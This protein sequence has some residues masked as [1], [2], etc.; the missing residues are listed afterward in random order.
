MRSTGKKCGPR[1]I[2]ARLNLQTKISRNSISC[3]E[4]ISILRMNNAWLPR[5]DKSLAMGSSHGSL[6]FVE[7][8]ADMR[9]LSGSR[10]G[11]CRQDV[12]I[13]EEAAG[14]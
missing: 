12:L 11:N 1:R 10:N 8:S 3:A 2:V 14:P 6:K 7:A 4:G 13:I 9:R 5:Q